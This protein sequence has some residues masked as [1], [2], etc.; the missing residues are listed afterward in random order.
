MD[1]DFMMQKFHLVTA[2]RSLSWQACL[3]PEQCTR[4]RTPRKIPNYYVVTSSSSMSSKGDPKLGHITQPLDR[5]AHRQTF[6][7]SLDWVH[8]T[9]L[10]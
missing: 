1:I 4:H 3:I 10:R 7:H 5:Q 8:S 2:L 6:I 9:T